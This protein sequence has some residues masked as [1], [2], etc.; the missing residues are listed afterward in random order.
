MDIS[1]IL[2]V[3]K[4]NEIGKNNDLVWHFHEDMKFFRETTT[5]NTVIMGRKTFESLPKVLPNRRNIVIS[6]DKSLKIDGAEVVRSVDEALEAAKND[7][8]FIIGGGRIYSEFLPLA[9]KLYL[10]EIDAECPEA[11]T[12]F[13]QFDKSEWSREV[14]SC[15]EENGIS[16]SH[17]LYIK[18]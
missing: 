5:G 6:S 7:K 4:N 16:F 11:D 13:P 18:K 9:T 17:V 8:I 1:L 12:F 10:T 15:A 2:S 3:G 14:L